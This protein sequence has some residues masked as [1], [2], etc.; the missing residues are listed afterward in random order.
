MEQAH[1]GGA[2]QRPLPMGE[3]G[4]RS[5]ENRQTKLD[6]INIHTRPRCDDG[7]RL[8]QAI[9]DIE[10]QCDWKVANPHQRHQGQAHEED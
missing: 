10:T 7:Q 8:K 5:H 6:Q 4:E 2:P 9:Q 1:Q 3:V